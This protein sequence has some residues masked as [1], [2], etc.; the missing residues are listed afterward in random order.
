MAMRIT[1][2][3]H[4]QAS[5]QVNTS[6]AQTQVIDSSIQHLDLLRSSQY[7]LLYRY[8][9]KQKLNIRTNGKNIKANQ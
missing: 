4:K 9:L 5:K 6:W 3:D 7:F 1:T 8:N 2:Y